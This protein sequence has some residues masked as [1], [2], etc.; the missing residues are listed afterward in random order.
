MVCSCI[1]PVSP[2]SVA[3]TLTAE[4]PLHPNGNGI[5]EYPPLNEELSN[6]V[7]GYWDSTIAKNLFAPSSPNGCTDVVLSLR[8]DLSCQLMNEPSKRNEFANW[9][10]KKGCELNAE[11]SNEIFVRCLFFTK[12]LPLCI[13]RNE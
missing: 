8:I 1:S 10:T 5:I 13:E 3:Q 11:E 12:S 7:G 2:Q 4:P 9:A 6:K